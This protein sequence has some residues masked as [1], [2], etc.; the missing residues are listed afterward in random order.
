[1]GSLRVVIVDDHRLMLEAIRTAL[2]N[3]DGIEVVGEATCGTQVLPLIGGTNPDVVLLDIRMPKMDGL[4]CLRAIRKR[5]PELKVA[6]FSG[7][8][9]P[10][11]IQESFRDGA[12]AF[13]GKNI[14]PR[15]L[16]SALRQAAE[17]TVYQ[18]FGVL[19]EG[20]RANEAGLTESETR[21]LNVLA[22]GFSNKEI[23][24]QLWLTEQTVKFHLTNIYRRLSV[25]NRTEAVR[26]AYEHRLVTP[27][28]SEVA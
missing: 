11:Q 9:E 13:I 2:E 4:A 18:P 21:V 23:A 5:F 24:K 27:S 20:N 7:F 28:H 3:S 8:D 19:D 22:Q 10:E 25:S 26:Y 6:M 17:G 14:D 12:S 15:D 16:A 1:M